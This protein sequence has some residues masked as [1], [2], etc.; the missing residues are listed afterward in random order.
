M[1][2]PLGGGA[3]GLA[4]GLGS[5]FGNTA[6]GGL[7]FGGYN[8]STSS[9]TYRSRSCAPTPSGPPRISGEALDG[10]LRS[11]EDD[12]E[13]FESYGGVNIMYADVPWPDAGAGRPNALL[14]HAALRAEQA[15]DARAAVRKLQVRWH[16]DKWVQRF[17]SRLYEGQAERVMARVKEISQVVNALKSK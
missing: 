1:G 14:S 10:M 11:H 8:Y 13:R 4:S 16:P 15:G 17:V 7:G 3:G 5:P 9:P 12:W 6:F 2:S